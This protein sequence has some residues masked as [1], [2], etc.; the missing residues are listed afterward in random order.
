MRSYIQR[1]QYLEPS[2]LLRPRLTSH[3]THGAH[4]DIYTVHNGV[5]CLK[6][7][8]GASDL[9]M[10]HLGAAARSVSSLASGVQV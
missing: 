7:D 5:N 4:Y 8:A 10:S 1:T 6:R 3:I 2:A 9:Q